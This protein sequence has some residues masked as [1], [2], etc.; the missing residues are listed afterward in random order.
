MLAA[1]LGES[2]LETLHAAYRL[3]GLVISRAAGTQETRA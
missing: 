3:L 1:G 2:G